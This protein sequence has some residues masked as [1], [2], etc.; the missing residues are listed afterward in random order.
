M[1][2]NLTEM[3]QDTQNTPQ[4]VEDVPSEPLTSEP[5]ASELK[6]GMVCE[7][8]AE[9]KARDITI[10]DVRGQTIVSDFF[11]VCSGTSI[12][13]IHSIAEGVRDHMREVAKQRTK[14]EGEAGSYW[15]IMDYSDVILHVFD[16]D[17]RE[18]YDLERLWADAKIS[19]YEDKGAPG[20]AQ[21]EAS[22][23]ANSDISS[24][25]NTI[26]SAES[27]DATAL[28]ESSATL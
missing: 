4:S 7:A 22:T 19:H 20:S 9:Q 10:L 16:E 25:R 3:S 27:H 28:S 23:E 18:F 17:T 11:V 21:L 5:L 26:S 2:E 12:T 15:I 13:H 8:L 1:T 24:T 14:P 6:L